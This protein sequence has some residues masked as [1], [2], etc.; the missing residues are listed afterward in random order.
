MEQDINQRLAAIE[1]DI[2]EN[3]VML[4]K[5]LRFQKMSVWSKWVYWGFIILLTLGAFAII[6]PTLNA[7]G[8]IYGSNSNVGLM[9]VL[10]NNVKILT[11]IANDN[12]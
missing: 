2:A 5:I 4:N 10:Q 8:G 7:L 12:Q 3:K 9:Q 1:K 11:E 6:K